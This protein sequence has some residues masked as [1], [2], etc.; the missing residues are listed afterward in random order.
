MKKKPVYHIICILTAVIA[1][2]FLQGFTQKAVERKEAKFRFAPFYKYSDEYDVLF[3]GNSH[4]INGVYTQELWKDYGI[5]S[6][7]MGGHAN[8]M[9]STYWQLV[10]ALESASP[11]LVVLDCSY[12]S[13]DWR[14]ME[15]DIELQHESWDMI[16][17]GPTKL[18]AA[19]DVTAY[20]TSS[21]EEQKKQVS[22]L[23]WNY[24]V[25]HNRWSSLGDDDK[26]NDEPG[27]HVYKDLSG[28]NV[29]L[30][31]E[32]RVDHSKPDSDA[33]DSYDGF[34]EGE[35]QGLI[36]L[37]KAIEH[38]K[39]KNQKL[40]LTF[41]PFP[42][43]EDDWQEINTARVIASKYNVPLVNFFDL[44]V[45]DLNTD[46][47][48]KTSHLNPSGARK[49]TAYLGRYLR[50]NYGLKDHRKEAGYSRWNDTYEEYQ[51]LK[52]AY[53]K[54]TKEDQERALLAQLY[55]PHMGVCVEIF[56]DEIYDSNTTRKLMKNIGIEENT[57]GK[58]WLYGAK[59]GDRLNEVYRS[60]NLAVWVS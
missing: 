16:P 25:F 17:A 27:V 55:N 8:Q 9:A 2:L 24:T 60:E 46:L 32:M 40:L 53:M 30:G 49:V 57:L 26:S 56:D 43:H 35:P 39:N 45:V 6:Y 47:F 13:H 54:A 12:I 1:F 33:L 22:E 14:L 11:E 23:M 20:D 58:V 48:D 18:K 7:N 50:D 41:L 29:E 34:I 37:K 15:D 4:M 44:N 42:A 10:C 59:K 5:A 36:Y 21:K 31:A 51:K 3:F 19:Y 28:Y 38:C 52:I